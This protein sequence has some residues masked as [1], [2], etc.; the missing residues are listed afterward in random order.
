MK[1]VF[2]GFPVNY[3]EILV[4]E[5]AMH[6]FRKFRIFWDLYEPNPTENDRMHS[7]TDGRTDILQIIIFDFSSNRQCGVIFF[8]FQEIKKILKIN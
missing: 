6:N 1:S 8:N 5:D 4:T 2:R 7:G 3:K